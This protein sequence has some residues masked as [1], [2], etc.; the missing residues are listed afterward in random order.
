M[1]ASEKTNA[2]Q[3]RCIFLMSSMS[4]S[5]CREKNNN[6]QIERSF[7]SITWAAVGNSCY[8]LIFGEKKILLLSKCFLQVMSSSGAKV[9][10]ALSSVCK[11]LSQTYFDHRD[12]FSLHVHK[13]RKPCG[14]LS[15]QFK[16]KRRVIRLQSIKIKTTK[17]RC[18]HF[19]TRNCQVSAA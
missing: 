2:K 7:L 9:D 8:L 5:V 11:G 18:K 10:V 1:A 15:C 4:L 16:K 3:R 6:I 12:G 17:T 14:F 19:L 13:K